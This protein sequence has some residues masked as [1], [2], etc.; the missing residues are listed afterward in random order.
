MGQYTEKP[1]Q[2]RIFGQTDTETD[3]GIQQTERT[4]KPTEKPITSDI[5]VF[6]ISQFEASVFMTE[7]EC[8][9]ALLHCIMQISQNYGS[10]GGPPHAQYIF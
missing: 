2:Y 7:I 3:V 10:V 8:N 6:I 5:S 4:E 1:N 9:Q